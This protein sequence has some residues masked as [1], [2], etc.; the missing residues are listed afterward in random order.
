MDSSLEIN[1]SNVS[2]KAFVD[3]KLKVFSK[4]LDSLEKTPQR[5]KNHL[6]TLVG[7]RKN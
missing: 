3:D 7:W 2:S 1:I 5:L 4:I 6:L